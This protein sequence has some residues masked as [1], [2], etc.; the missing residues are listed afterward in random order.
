MA[1]DVSM[2]IIMRTSLTNAL[3]KINITI[4]PAENR[5]VSSIIT[6]DLVFVCPLPNLTTEKTV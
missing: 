6:R 5:S 2:L 1:A 3:K 4:E